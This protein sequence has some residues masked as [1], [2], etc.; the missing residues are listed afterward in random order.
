M[1][2]YAF[3]RGKCKRFQKTYGKTQNAEVDCQKRKR[4]CEHAIQIYSHYELSSLSQIYKAHQNQRKFN[5]V[6]HTAQTV[7]IKFRNFL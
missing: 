3:T 6:R 7:D 2:K 5:S 4:K 1:L